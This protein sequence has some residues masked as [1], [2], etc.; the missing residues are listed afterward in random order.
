MLIEHRGGRPSVHPSAYVAPTATLSGD[1][2]V[3]ERSRILFGAVVTAD[4]GPVV[5]GAETIVME[6]AVVRGTPRDPAWIGSNVLIGPRSSLSGC[7]VEDEAFIA[8]GA[9]VFNGAVIGRRAEVRV[10]GV[11]H[12]RTALP[13][14]GLVPIGWVAVGDPVQVFPP[15]EH[16]AIWAVQRDL[17]FPRNVFGL[18]RNELGNEL[19]RELTRRYARGLAAHLDDVVVG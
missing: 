3:G 2:T 16:D 1:V 7:T 12:V 5:I 6:N 9:T 11:V 4:G 18:D 15:T 19:Q 8:T 10:N 13:E 14:G 17:D